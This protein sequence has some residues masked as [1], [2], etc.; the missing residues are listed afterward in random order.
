MTH[1]G[2]TPDH[3]PVCREAGVPSGGIAFAAV[4][5]GHEAAS[6]EDL[7]VVAL[8][9]YA[10]A[11]HGPS[12]TQGVCRCGEPW[13][14]MERYL[15]GTGGG[16]REFGEIRAQVNA[17]IVDRAHAIVERWRHGGTV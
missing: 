8:A 3:C 6:E 2:P 15:G 12:G 17:V 10:A 13:G 14:G 7:D 9:E 5:L 11:A 1:A 4:L 16:C